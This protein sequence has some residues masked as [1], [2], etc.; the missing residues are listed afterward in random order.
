[1]PGVRKA[2][3]KVRECI[4]LRKLAAEGSELQARGPLALGQ[5]AGVHQASRAPHTHPR[6]GGACPLPPPPGMRPSPRGVHTC[7]DRSE[8]RTQLK[9]LLSKW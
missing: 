3:G 9:A 7:Q 2:A 8:A 1:M 5:G 6:S 4:S